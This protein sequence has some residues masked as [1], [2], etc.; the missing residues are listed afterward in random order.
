MPDIKVIS[1]SVGDRKGYHRNFSPQEHRFARA[2]EYVRAVRA[3]KLERL[4]A[5]PFVAAFDGHAETV[6]KLI[7]VRSKLP[8]LVSGDWDG[9]I[10]CWD[11]AQHLLN[12][13]VHGHKGRVMG[14]TTTNTG[15]RSVNVNKS[16]NSDEIQ[17]IANGNNLVISTGI[18]KTIKIW[19]LNLQGTAR[20]IGVRDDVTGWEGLVQHNGNNKESSHLG[21][22]IPISTIHHWEPF[23]CV[24]ACWEYNSTLYATG[25]TSVRLWDINRSHGLHNFKGTVD[26]VS[27]M[28]FNPSQFN[29]LAVG[30]QDRKITFYDTRTKSPLPYITLLVESVLFCFVLFCDN[31]YTLLLS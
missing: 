31:T 10:R 13:R 25:S 16:K 29:I 8:I 5:K 12:W 2:R 21:D 24:D 15:T 7:K 9:E 4:H 27:C 26:Q 11:M 23:H 14:L 3:A 20:K 18:D 1:R 19:K 28:A 17:Y 22:Q 30:M 6:C